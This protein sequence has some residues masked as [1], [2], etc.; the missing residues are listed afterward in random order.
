MHIPRDFNNS[1]FTKA[2][3][4]SQADFDFL[5]AIKGKKSRAGKLDEVIA[6]YRE[7]KHLEKYGTKDLSI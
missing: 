6:F 4:V 3:R 1:R 2:I 5:D 7:S